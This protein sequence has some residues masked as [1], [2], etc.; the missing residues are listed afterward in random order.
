MPSFLLRKLLYLSLLCP[1]MTWAQSAQ[2]AT[3]LLHSGDVDGAL[4]AARAAVEADPGDTESHALLIDILMNQGL[5]ATAQ[6]VYGDFAKKNPNSARTWSLLGRASTR[7]AAASEAYQKALDLDPHYARA[8]CGMGDIY[9]ATGETDYAVVAYEK[10]IELDSRLIEAYTGLGALYL[11]N[12]NHEKSLSVVRQ[13]MVHVPGDSE[14][15]LAAAGLNP[16]QAMTFLEK[17]AKNAS[18]DPRIHAALGHAYLLRGQ[19]LQARQSLKKALA[20]QPYFAQAALNLQVLDAIQAGVLSLNGWEK[21][22]RAKSHL[23]NDNPKAI[24][25][26]KQL[27]TRFPQCHLVKLSLARALVAGNQLDAA[28]ARLEEAMALAPMDADVHATLGLLLQNRD[29]HQAALPH[30]ETAA[31]ARPNDPSL[32]IAFGVSATN[33]RGPRAGAEILAAAAERFPSDPRPAM[34]LSQLLTQ[35]GDTQSAY[36]VL[37]RAVTQYPSPDLL[38]AL[39]GAAKAIGK[40]NEAA[41]ALRRLAQ[42]TGDPSWQRAAETLPQ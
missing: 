31:L 24:V 5:G 39:A 36:I 22:N 40:N 1:T 7:A 19:N 30:L 20:I 18:H 28:Q 33:V 42:I 13:A 3:A 16:E 32:Q 27:N 6:Q 17:G 37:E 2:E 10:A 12:G 23:A 41:T 34:A 8:W 15:Y 35:N 38:L 4:G 9:R 21:L 29:R 14:A 11:K 26:Y 25:L